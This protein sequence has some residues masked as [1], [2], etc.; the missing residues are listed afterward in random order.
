MF[1]PI[2]QVSFSVYYFYNKFKKKIWLSPVVQKQYFWV[3]LSLIQQL[4]GKSGGHFTRPDKPLLDH[5]SALVCPADWVTSLFCLLENYFSDC[6]LTIVSLFLSACK[7]LLNKKSDGV[8]VSSLIHEGF[9]DCIA[10][11][12]LTLPV[13][14]PLWSVTL[15]TL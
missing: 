14:S 11:V 10:S 1:F 6:V 3:G 8:K 12:L 5:V 15:T 13:F 2:F 9:I 7:T 4:C